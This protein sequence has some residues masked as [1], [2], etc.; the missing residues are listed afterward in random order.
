MGTQ[1]PSLGGMIYLNIRAEARGE[2]VFL[3][4]G[5]K[6]APEL[7]FGDL[8]PERAELLAADLLTAAASARTAFRERLLLERSR[9]E[10]QLAG[11]DKEE[12]EK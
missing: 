9:I 3:F 2:E 6:G 12:S 7:L 11:L 4:R 8:T 10:E 5:T 1:F